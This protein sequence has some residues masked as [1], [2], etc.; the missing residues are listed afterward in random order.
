MGL[1]I[2]WDWKIEIGECK[3]DLSFILLI[4]WNENLFRL[5]REKKEKKLIETWNQLE[6]KDFENYGMSILGASF[7][8]Y[9]IGGLK[10]V[11]YGT[12]NFFERL[13]R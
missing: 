3:G 6:K 10:L 1:E 7:T 4:E 13:R 12:E 2:R 9:C 5:M 11:S 8:E